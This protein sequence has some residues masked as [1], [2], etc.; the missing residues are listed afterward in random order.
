MEIKTIEWLLEYSKTIY[1]NELQRERNII[2]QATRIQTAFSFVIISVITIIQILLQYW[3]DAP[4]K[5][6]VVAASS[7]IISLVL[8][9]VF[10]TVAQWRKKRKDFPA[11]DSI[12]NEVLANE[13]FFTSPEQKNYY[14][15]ETYNQMHKT[16]EKNNNWRNT[17][18]K[19]SMSAFFVSLAICAVWF[20]VFICL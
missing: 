20:I 12:K 3:I 9:L 4:K 5:V 10:A 1:E 11:V 2:S 8:S 16:L 15:I 13:T 14:L 7:I 18:L 17:Y 6:I 19:F